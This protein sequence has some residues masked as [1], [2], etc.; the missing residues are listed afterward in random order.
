VIIRTVKRATEGILPLARI[1]IEIGLT[2]D[3]NIQRAALC[4]AVLD[5]CGVTV[6]GQRV[7]CC[8]PRAEKP[9]APDQCTCLVGARSAIEVALKE[10][11]E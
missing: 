2:A 9:N 3:Q 4:F 6:D 10:E 1:Y 5:E 7:L 11:K 8:D